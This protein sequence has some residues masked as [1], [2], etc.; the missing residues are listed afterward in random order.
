MTNLDFVLL[1]FKVEEQAE[2]YLADLR[3]SEVHVYLLE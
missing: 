1:D 2:E 3:A